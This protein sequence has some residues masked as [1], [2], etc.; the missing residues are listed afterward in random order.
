MTSKSATLKVL[1]LP[2]VYLGDTVSYKAG[3]APT[4][5]VG[6]GSSE[7]GLKYYAKGLP[8][9]LKINALTGEIT[10]SISA[11]AGTY[12]V[13]YWTQAGKS[14]SAIQTLTFVVEPPLPP[15]PIGTDGALAWTHGGGSFDQSVKNTAPEAAGLTYEA[16]GLPKGLKIDKNTGQIYG[17]I[18]AKP[19]TYTV[20]YWSKA[21]STKSDPVTLQFTV[22]AF[23]FE[24]DYDALFVDSTDHGLPA[25]KV[26]VKITYNGAFTGKLYYQ[27]NKT[28]S[29]KG[30][31]GLN[32][33]QDA[34]SVVLD[35]VGRSGLNLD[36]YVTVGGKLEAS[37]LADGATGYWVEAQYGFESLKL[38]NPKAP[39]RTYTVGAQE[40]W[41]NEVGS[42]TFF[43][44]LTTA[45]LRGDAKISV[46]SKNVL[47]FKGT[48]A[49]GTKITTSTTGSDDGSYL[50]FVNPNKKIWGGYFSGELN[51]NLANNRFDDPDQN[52][53]RWSK[54]SPDNN[55]I[56]SGAF[57]PLDVTIET[58]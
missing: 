4:L 27:N 56:H 18:T 39:V 6:L 30:I 11:K 38:T 9:G 46:S 10:G 5:D 36:L 41:I 54:P 2:P 17:N 43:D 35:N 1:S 53:L 24:G 32:G 7:S 34:A 23:P 50:L 58:K 15:A 26:T 33:A 45:P 49:D 31:F 44:L 12:N 28:Y 48:A 57:G 22:D 20:T 8:K 37:T 40:V 14:K 55:K 3:S 52:D 42:Q 13:T 21:G 19:G 51:L 25:G 29:F 47:S 16:K